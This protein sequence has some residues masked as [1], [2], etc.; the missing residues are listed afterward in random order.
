MRGLSSEDCR[1]CDGLIAPIEKIYQAGGHFHTDG[2][3]VVKAKLRRAGAGIAVIDAGIT[4]ASGETVN[5]VGDDPVRYPA[6]KHIVVCKLRPTDDG[7]VVT[8]L[9]FL[10]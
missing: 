3:A 10:S 9:G 6:E 8:F 7:W 5:E 1:S 4:M 2:W